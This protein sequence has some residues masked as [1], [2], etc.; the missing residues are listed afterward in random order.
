MFISPIIL[1][2]GFWVVQTCATHAQKAQL[3]RY[4]SNQLS[5]KETV[6]ACIL[7]HLQATS[8]AQTPTSCEL[9]TNGGFELNFT[10]FNVSTTDPADFRV[11]S[12]EDGEAHSGTQFLLTG[13][14]TA[15]PG[16]TISQVLGSC[17]GIAPTCTLSLYLAT[18]T[19]FGVCP[20]PTMPLS[21]L[22]PSVTACILDK[23]GDPGKYVYT[24]C[25]HELLCVRA[26]KSLD[27]LCFVG[28]VCIFLKHLE[29]DAFLAA[30][31]PAAAIATAA[32]CQL[33]N[34]IVAC[35]TDAYVRDSSHD[36]Y[37]H[38]LFCLLC[39]AQL[40]VTVCCQSL[41]ETSMY[42]TAGWMQA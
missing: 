20:S 11:V 26:L 1:A 6:K 40:A 12:T 27:M 31:A 34:N 17:P 24:R 9:V 32:A 18:A 2:F 29:N 28:S 4:N 22:E 33:D 19:G 8:E 7:S 23:L 38:N 16:G 42:W 21:M 41:W 10:G 13:Q 36:H 30:V 3:D 14:N 39:R 35:F 37:L 15:S 5:C 25:N